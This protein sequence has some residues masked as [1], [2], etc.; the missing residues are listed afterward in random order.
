M[1]GSHTDGG[2]ED[3]SFFQPLFLVGAALPSWMFHSPPGG[4]MGQIYNLPWNL[5]SRSIRQSGEGDNV[6]E[7]EEEQD[8]VEGLK[9]EQ[10]S[11][12]TFTPWQQH[13]H[14]QPQPQPN[15]LSTDHPSQH[16]SLH[17]DENSPPASVQLLSPPPMHL[18]VRRS[19]RRV[20]E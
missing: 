7:G 1:G 12:S 6:E 10:I 16:S 14:T 18:T 5:Y 3:G 15:Y 20:R 11:A 17:I 13:P 8:D 2:E 4:Q 19:R 9:E